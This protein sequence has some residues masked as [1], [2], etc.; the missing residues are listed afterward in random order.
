[1]TL[2]NADKNSQFIEKLSGTHLRNLR[3]KTG[4]NP[5]MT[6]MNADK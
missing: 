5:Q 1:M 2:M 6:P 4:K 3:I